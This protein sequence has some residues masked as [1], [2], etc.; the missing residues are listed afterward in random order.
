[1]RLVKKILCTACQL[2]YLQAAENTWV[3]GTASGYAPFVNLS[4]QGELEGFDI[5]VAKDL[6]QRMEKTLVLKDLGSLNTLA[7]ALEQGKI[8]SII[9]AISITPERCK[10]MRML[11]Y[12]GAMV[13]SFPLLFY[14]QIPDGITKLEDLAN[15][16][17]VTLS[18]EAGSIQETFL[19]SLEGVQVQ[20]SDS[21]TQGILDLR[22]GKTTALLIDPSLK[23][24]II[25][26]VPGI[27]SLDIV[28]PEQFCSY[29]HGICLRL[30]DTALAVELEQ[31]IADMKQ[32]GTVRRLESLWGIQ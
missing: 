19:Q 21:I 1:M 22:F 5:D 15:K 29:G 32:D 11:H 2:F 25:E 7:M 14:R 27:K 23:Q 26:K 4:E 9:W 10:K 30:D 16:P 13:S 6:A 28:L 3:V 18:V 12:Q 17:E 20:C 8:D 31:S 24:Q